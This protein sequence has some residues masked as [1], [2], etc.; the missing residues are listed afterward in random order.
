MIEKFKQETNV[1][2]V[3]TFFSPSGYEVRKNYEMADI[4]LYLPLD[5]PNNA[6][7]FVKTLN[8]SSSFLSSMNCGF[9]SL[10]HYRKKENCPLFN[11]SEMAERKTKFFSF[12]FQTFIMGL[13]AFTTIFTQDEETSILLQNFL[14]QPQIITTGDTRFDRILATK[15]DFGPFPK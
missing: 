11:R 7:F 2:I 9:I 12:L 13:N 10:Q 6:R 14:T 15:N 4:V 3:L 5:T 8:P 1:K